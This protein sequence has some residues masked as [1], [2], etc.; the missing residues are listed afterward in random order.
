ML[1]LLLTA[2]GGAFGAAARHGVNAAMAASGRRMSF[3][4]L[5]VNVLGS[6]AAGW[7]AG[8]F[9]RPGAASDDSLRC[10]LLVGFLGAFT[11]F[12]AFSVEAAGFWREGKIA[13][14]AASAASNCLLSLAAAL[15]GGRLAWQGGT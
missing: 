11:T 12:S 14:L 7:L 1:N 5:A 6:F 4:T 10:F 3:A 8:R 9:S 2:I 13:W 15:A